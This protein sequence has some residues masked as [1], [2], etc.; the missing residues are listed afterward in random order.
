VK[1]AAFALLLNMC[2]DIPDVTFPPLWIIILIAISLS[3]SKVSVH[4][5]INNSGLAFAGIGS[6]S[7]Q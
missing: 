1:W 3:K 5:G 6:T 2:I 4:Q 7:L